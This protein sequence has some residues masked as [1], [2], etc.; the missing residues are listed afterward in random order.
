MHQPAVYTVA[1]QTFNVIS[2]LPVWTYNFPEAIVKREWSHIKPAFVLNP[3][4]QG[5]AFKNR[6]LIGVDLC[7]CYSLIAHPRGMQSDLSVW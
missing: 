1:L 2:F 6:V 3:S 5:V 7:A 4:H